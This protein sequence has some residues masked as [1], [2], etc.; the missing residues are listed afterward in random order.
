M[1]FFI[2]IQL[3]GMLIALV[4]HVCSDVFTRLGRAS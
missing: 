2:G 4:G 1:D 3:I